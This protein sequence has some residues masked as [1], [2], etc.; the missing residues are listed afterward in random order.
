MNNKRKQ[1]NARIQEALNAKRKT[2]KP[3]K[4][5]GAP[6][7]QVDLEAI[8][9]HTRTHEINTAQGLDGRSH[10][11]ETPVIVRDG[12]DPSFAGKEGLNATIMKRS[13]LSVMADMVGDHNVEIR[14]AEG[15]L[16]GGTNGTRA[17]CLKIARAFGVPEE[18]IS[19]VKASLKQS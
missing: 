4:K 2:A 1:E 16:L 14:S 3:A 17:E 19:F 13:K 18:N 6:R 10:R 11:L 12:L 9:A 8:E 7:V 5:K 15:V